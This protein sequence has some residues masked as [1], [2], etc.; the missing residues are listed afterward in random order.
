LNENIRAKKIMSEPMRIRAVL[1]NGVVEVKLMIRHVM[2]T[3]LRKDEQGVRIP[4]HYIETLVV[5]CKD[6]IVLDA[7]L[8]MA[9][10]QNPYIA[11]TFR[12]AAKGD[13]IE[14]S[15]RDNLGDTRV[16]ESVIS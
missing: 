4:A 5:R 8:G 14:A 12:D 2:E 10:S 11:F 6:K 3:G 7:H 9:V 16:D 15:W 13:R 1:F